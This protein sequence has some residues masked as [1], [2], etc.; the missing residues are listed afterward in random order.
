MTTP[1]LPGLLLERLG[2]LGQ[3]G[4]VVT[5]GCSRHEVRAVHRRAITEVAITAPAGPAHLV[6]HGSDAAT[7]ST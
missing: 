6:D 3:V 7:P 4:V 5:I 1:P 2:R